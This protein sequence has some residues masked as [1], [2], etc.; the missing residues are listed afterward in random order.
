[1]W[2]TGG[3][4]PNIV[5]RPGD[6]F[7]LYSSSKISIILRVV[8]KFF[9]REVVVL[10]AC[11]VLTLALCS[12]MCG[13]GMGCE[14]LLRSKANVAPNN[15]PAY[16]YFRRTEGWRW[17]CVLRGH[18]GLTMIVRPRV[19]CDLTGKQLNYRVV[20][21]LFTHKTSRFPHGI[22]NNLHSSCHKKNSSKSTFISR[23]CHEFNMQP[24]TLRPFTRS[25]AHRHRP[26]LTTDLFPPSFVD[27][28]ISNNPYHILLR[29]LLRFG[30]ASKD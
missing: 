2:I 17:T 30:S 3:K 15:L 6:T 27:F 4:V 5:S 21:F 7:G 9:E 26:E 29:G 18:Q 8:A 25:T 12:R 11:G 10:G 28:G 24:S 14:G 19:G 20:R 23:V 1:M 16:S 13:I 22:G